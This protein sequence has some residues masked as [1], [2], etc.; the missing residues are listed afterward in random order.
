MLQVATQVRLQYFIRDAR[1]SLLQF[2]VVLDLATGHAPLPCDYEVLR[3]IVFTEL[4]K[5][6]FSID[7]VIQHL[8]M[9]GFFIS[10]K[11][12]SFI[13][14]LLNI[15]EVAYSYR[16]IL[17]HHWE[18]LYHA[19]SIKELML[20]FCSSPQ[21]CSSISEVL[22]KRASIANSSYPS[23]FWN[24]SQSVL[25]N[26]HLTIN[27]VIS[28]QQIV[29]DFPGQSQCLSRDEENELER[30]IEVLA[31]ITKEGMIDIDEDELNTLAGLL[32]LQ[33][34][35]YL[36]LYYCRGEESAAD[37][38]RVISNLE[39]VYI[40]S[41]TMSLWFPSLPGIL[42]R[43]LLSRYLI[44]KDIEDLHQ[45]IDIGENIIH[46]PNSE[47]KCEILA[48]PLC[49]S[50]VLS[51]LVLRAYKYNPEQSVT[52]WKKILDLFERNIATVHF[53]VY[54]SW[55]IIASIAL[56]R[57]T[58]NGQEID[59]DKISKHFDGW[60]LGSESKYIPQLYCASLWGQLRMTTVA[61]DIKKA[62]AIYKHIEALDLMK[63]YRNFPFIFRDYSNLDDTIS[64]LK[65][66]CP[67]PSPTIN[68]GS[69][70]PLVLVLAAT[71]YSRYQKTARIKDL[72]DSNIYFLWSQQ[73]QSQF[74]QQGFS[75]DLAS[76]M[77]YMN[78]GGTV[79]RARYIDILKGAPIN[80][81]SSNIKRA[82]AALKRI[83][84]LSFRNKQGQSIQQH[85]FTDTKQTYRML[86]E[87]QSWKHS[88]SSSVASDTR[89][90]QI[91][92]S[93]NL[94]GI[95]TPDNWDSMVA[96]GK[97]S[98]T[99]SF[100]LAVQMLKELCESRQPEV[101]K[102]DY[103]MEALFAI[104]LWINY[105]PGILA[106]S[107]SDNSSI[108]GLSY[109]LIILDK[110]RRSEL[111]DI[112][113]YTTRNAM[114]QIWL[115]LCLKVQ[116]S[117]VK[118]YGLLYVNE[119]VDSLFHE[120][121]EKSWVASSLW[122]SIVDRHEYKSLGNIFS[123]C[124]YSMTKWRQGFMYIVEF[125][126]RWLGM[127]WSQLG[128]LR[129]P[130]NTLA[131]VNPELAFRLRNVS[132]TLE[133][134]WVKFDPTLWDPSSLS[135]LKISNFDCFEER[136]RILED[137]RMIPGFQDFFQ[138]RSFQDLQKAAWD[139]GPV[140]INLPP[141]PNYTI[142]IF[143]RNSHPESKSDSPPCISDMMLPMPFLSKLH[144]RFREVTKMRSVDAMPVA[145]ADAFKERCSRVNIYSHSKK[146]TDL[147]E[148]LLEDL[149]I[150]IVKPILD[151]L[152]HGQAS[153]QNIKEES[154]AW[155]IPVSISFALAKV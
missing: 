140:V 28:M 67:T 24:L 48:N 137:I 110:M 111:S 58:L 53:T 95:V 84:H 25:S 118:A 1:L 129:V 86:V 73:D 155:Q 154:K 18:D 19:I 92:A 56:Y 138:P 12:I 4:D 93:Y 146:Q 82:Q 37:L 80:E 62:L 60:C 100:N 5:I 36:Q 68:C 20:P 79:A 103:C 99:E 2:E 16:Y 21:D 122:E 112:K 87:Q 50:S 124:I 120:M 41:G 64:L 119:I 147:M 126:E 9:G 11:F 66:S 7:E 30:G 104:S 65:Q 22:V 133:E 51:A 116:N 132:K 10:S 106:Q 15:K 46:S 101:S 127:I 141:Q 130:L 43:C 109:V 144:T 35:A 105:S 38:D 143:L 113:K 108:E 55:K 115:I 77:Y 45:I 151:H 72:Q 136:Q 17:H 13:F 74:D 153:Q 150:H 39:T 71:L 97:V 131:V 70:R 34:K 98:V 149:W 59:I 47:G 33:G 139:S 94:T 63:T 81:H 135:P 107:L 40:L 26:L 114:Y 52:D 89:L 91:A 23:S 90:E 42:L 117:E 102:L 14:K 8:E 3:D 32:F 83:H 76:K 57:L 69:L 152:L 96:A 145:E 128:Q 61:K 123:L 121:E 49:T 29:G 148:Q 125:N 78:C 134:R 54:S 142:F 27:F 88:E 85:S 75:D 44:F 6:I 31:G